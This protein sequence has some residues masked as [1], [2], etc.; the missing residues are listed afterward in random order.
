MSTS[1][2]QISSSSSSTRLLQRAPGLRTENVT[3]NFLVLVSAIIGLSNQ[4]STMKAVNIAI[5]VLSVVSA[6]CVQIAN[7]EAFL[8]HAKVKPV[9]YTIS[10]AVLSTAGILD[11]IKSQRDIRLAQSPAYNTP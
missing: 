2:L 10:W 9:L 4:Q 3:F 5:I 7:T 6:A 8:I 1:P 11:V